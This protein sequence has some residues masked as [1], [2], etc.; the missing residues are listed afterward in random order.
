MTFYTVLTLGRVSN[1]PTL[2]SNVMV[3][4]ALAGMPSAPV[5]IALCAFSLSLIYTAGFLFNDV[6]DRQFDAQHRPE[7]PIPM[8][9]VGVRVVVAWGSAM[10]ALALFLLGLNAALQPEPPWSGVVAGLVL[11]GLVLV[12]DY[13][14]KSNP[15]GPL[16]MG[17]CRGLVYITV[18]LSLGAGWSLQLGLFAA[19]LT[20]WVLGLTL[21]AKQRNI[22]LGVGLLIACV[23]AVLCL[24]GL[25]SLGLWVYL[26]LTLLS[27]GWIIG[28]VYWARRHAAW[29]PV[30]LLIASISLLDAMVIMQQTGGVNLMVLA[31]VS[32]FFVTL[33]LQR[34]IA[35]S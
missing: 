35:G 17:L 21:V 29:N 8:H 22:L 13:W 3:G 14:H 7:R 11:C 2:W 12:Y 5:A 9:A 25:E 27:T 32:L 30:T 10:L 33:W 1:L 18:A 15:F 6:F 28:C 31:A 4:V 19:C 16:L 26:L 24:T 20:T 23:Q 34:H